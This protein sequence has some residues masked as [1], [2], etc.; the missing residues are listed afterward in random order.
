MQLIF[1]NWKAKFA[2]LIL[3]TFVWWVIDNQLNQDVRAS[4]PKSVPDAVEL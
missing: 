1:Q 3:A 2:C 4:A